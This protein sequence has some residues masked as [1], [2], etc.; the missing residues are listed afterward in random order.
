MEHYTNNNV[1]A[2]QRVLRKRAEAVMSK[3]DP[4]QSGIYNYDDDYGKFSS[5]LQHK[6]NEKEQRYKGR[7]ES[8]YISKLLEAAKAETENKI[9]KLT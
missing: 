2:E 7:T 9:L 5:R 8:W 6:R 1:A 4:N 3:L